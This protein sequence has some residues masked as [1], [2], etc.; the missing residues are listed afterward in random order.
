MGSTAKSHKGRNFKGNWL[1]VSALDVAA[2]SPSNQIGMFLNPQIINMI[3]ETSN[4]KQNPTQEEG[5]SKG[6]KEE[7]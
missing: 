6:E 2:S 3:I 5:N 4:K 7:K 1:P